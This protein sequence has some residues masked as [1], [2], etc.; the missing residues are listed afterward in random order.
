M[1]AICSLLLEFFIIIKHYFPCVFFSFRFYEIDFQV[2]ME[3]VN[4]SRH[5][6]SLVGCL[7]VNLLFYFFLIDCSDKAPFRFFLISFSP[8]SLL[9]ERERGCPA[10]PESLRNRWQ[11]M[12][13]AG[14]RVI[15]S[16]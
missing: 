12:E 16:I 8:S 3:K 15:I 9:K 4:W 2:K 5:W 14:R 7:G 13:P 6:L 1:S 10:V 11:A